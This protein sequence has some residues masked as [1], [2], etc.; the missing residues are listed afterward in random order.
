M[1][2]DG[3]DLPPFK[4]A[5][6][7]LAHKL[8][9]VMAFEGVIAMTLDGVPQGPKHMVREP[10]DKGPLVGMLSGHST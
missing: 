1:K 10:S 3:W 7:P 2:N 5:L 6:L 8:G 9:R 4:R